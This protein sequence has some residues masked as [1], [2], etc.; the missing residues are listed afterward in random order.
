MRHTVVMGKRNVGTFHHLSRKHLWRYVNEFVGRYNI[1]DW[2]MIDQ[3]RSIARGLLG[4]RLTYRG[5]TG[6]HGP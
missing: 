5:L 6:A 4:R 3:M 1:R 2:D